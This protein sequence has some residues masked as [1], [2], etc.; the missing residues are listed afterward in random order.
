[1]LVAEL[2][3]KYKDFLTTKMPM[4]LKYFIGW[5]FNQCHMLMLEL[6]QRHYLQ[7]ANARQPF[8]VVGIDTN[9]GRIPLIKLVKLHQ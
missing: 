1:M 6:M 3:A 5:P 7:S 8:C 2:S 9:R 4:G